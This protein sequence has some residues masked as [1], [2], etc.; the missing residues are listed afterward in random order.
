METLNEIGLRHGTD[1]ASSTHDYLNR[2]ESFLKEYKDKEIT[3]LEIGCAGANSIRM[4]REWMPKARVFT[5]DINP[6]CATYTEGV[7]IGS[8]TD[9]A[10]LDDLIS[11]IGIPDVIISDGSHVGD[12]E[13]I[14]FKH[15]FPKLKSGGLYFLEDTAAAL[16]IPTYS[17]EFENNGRSRAFNFFS[18]LMYDIDV[19][20][21][22]CCG[23]AD[24]CINHASETPAVPEF[25]RVLESMTITCSLHLFKRR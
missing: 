20:G 24:F 11:K 22:G 17:G 6:D 25:S 12:E 9:H 3:L 4:W 13:V 21:K 23:N 2:Y 7:F 8:Q 16:Y 15:L 5:I 18:D 1:K 19:A 10:F 14:T